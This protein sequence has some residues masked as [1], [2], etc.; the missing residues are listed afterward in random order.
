VIILFAIRV[1]IPIAVTLAFGKWLEK[2]LQPQPDE[3]TKAAAE[4]ARRARL[5]TIVQLHCWDL[6]HCETN[7]VA[8]CA[9]CQHPQLPCWLA[10]QVAGGKVREECFTCRLYRAELIT[11]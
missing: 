8:K 5:N 7:N 4:A 9:A 6:K 1:A 3:A 10:I 11:A 2:K